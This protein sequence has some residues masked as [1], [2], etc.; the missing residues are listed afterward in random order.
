MATPGKP[1]SIKNLVK[2]FASTE[3]LQG[4]NLDVKTGE[5]ISILGPSGCGKSTILRI[6]AGLD[7]AT[8]GEVLIGAKAVTH[9]PAWEREIGLVFQNF[10]LWPHMTAL[11]NVA[12]GLELRKLSKDECRRRALEALRLVRLEH[13]ATRYPS[14]LSGGQ[15]QRVAIARATVINPSVLLLDEPLSALDKSLRKDM[16]LEIKSIQQKLGITTIFVTHDQ[17]EAMSLSDRIVVMRAG[18]IVQIDTP[19]RLY[20]NPV[21]RYVAQFVGETNL[22]SG[23]P[24]STPEGTFLPADGHTHRVNSTREGAS[25]GDESHYFVRPEWIRIERDLSADTGVLGTIERK[26]FLGAAVDYYARVGARLIHVNTVDGS[27]KVGEQVRL[28]FALQEIQG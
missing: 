11:E 4:V 10:A 28:Q 8:S 2:R 21:D 23:H 25:S 14:Q 3:V 13:L 15:Q 17:E 27:I 5:F 20:S 1:V 9:L 26:V 18:K 24:V 7:F 22:F 19:E 12:F 16:Q 6:V